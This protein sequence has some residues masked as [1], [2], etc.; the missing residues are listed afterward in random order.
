MRQQRPTLARFAW[1]LT[2]LIATPALAQVDARIVEWV[3]NAP[4]TNNSV[5]ALGYPVPI[6]V[7]TPLPFAG[8]RTYTGLHTRHQDLAAT[9]P[10]VHAENVGATRQGRTIWMYRLG[11]ADF[12]TARGTPEQ[13]MLSNGGIHAREWQ[14][15]EVAT[16]IMELIATSA[17][18]HHLLSYLR[19]NANVM[20]I[21]V[22]NVDGFLQTQRY[23]AHN[24]LGT[25]PNYPEE[26][27]RDGRMR[28][29]NM[30]GNPDDNLLTVDD[31]LLGVDLNRNNAPFW[32][33]NPQRS[34]NNPA[35]LVHHGP[36]QASEPETRA[37]DA[38]A[39]FGPADQ[40]SMYTDMHSF[41]QVHFWGR[42]FNSRLTDLTE[43]LL[44]TFSDHHRQFPAGKNYAYGSAQSV[45]LNQGIGTTDEYF[46]YTYRV[47][48]WT[49]E[50]E[51]S[52][53]APYH[54]PLPGMGADYGGLG[55][56]GHDGF[57]LPDSEVER[58]RTELARTFAV[59]YYQ[60]AG[61]PSVTALRM[62]DSTTGA[63]VF[64]AEW[65]AISDTER[66]L[67]RFQSQPLQLG[68][69]Y[70][71]WIAWDK[72][73][74]WR[75]NGSV[76]PLPGQPGST[77]DLEGDLTAADGTIE[78]ELIA[79]AWLDQPGGAPWGYQR[80]RDD[81]VALGVRL[82]DT[83]ANQDLVQAGVEATLHL[84]TFDMTGNRT[85]ANPATVAR[86][87]NGGWSGY[88]NTE[89]VDGTD[90][91]GS[92]ASIQFAVTAEALEDPF[93][94]E[95]GTSG[96]WFDPD[97]NGEGFVLE[98][99]D[100]SRAVMYWFTYDAEGAQDWYV[101]TGEIR[102]NRILFPDLLRV[103]GGRFGPD[104]DPEQV[105]RTPVGS[106]DFIFSSCDSGA[107]NWVIDRDGG[108][109][110]Q[111]RMDLTRLS[112]VMGIPC[113]EFI[114]APVLEIS[115]RSGSW[116]DPTHSG[117]G[118]ALEILFDQRALVYWFSFDPEGNR[119]WFFGTG[120][121]VGGDVLV[122]DDM[123]TTSGGI[124]GA[125]FD[126]ASVELS[127]WGSLQ[128]QLDCDTGTAEYEP[129]GEDFPAGTLDL[130]RLTSVAGLDCDG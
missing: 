89:G 61:P 10:W 125:E 98:I 43:R 129:A 102:G 118:Y 87:F 4:V 55:R 105:V 63:T 11:D 106:A 53:G 66:R 41:S 16:G 79:G 101:A 51:P 21:P 96:A 29:K 127:P 121:I 68:R 37:L 65:D 107:M 13:A 18:D 8:F 78:T 130:D 108:D 75:E 119:R 99:L 91:G 84:D 122:F 12:L 17:D 90:E 1:L 46:L 27:P 93:V 40:L 123:L 76:V 3:E 114:G 86:W 7:D 94:I 116:Y 111:G 59:A 120:E 85:D 58:V 50:I 128:L 104:F 45:P 52:N 73:M 74:R 15:P 44:R 70:R 5:I 113:N 62:I 35:S 54:A 82:L 20:V 81:A 39:Q 72:P 80:Y 126:P 103:S 30:H 33:S 49:L 48:S 19:E 56:N 26:S 95:P 71:V 42:T 77:L 9:T 2:L 31:H 124:F 22:L 92:D 32:A 23:P 67:H 24:W 6:P 109:R 112:R 28:R 38:A 36:S 83:P 64:E 34:S 14:S 110:R 60:Q 88:E 100:E 117:E 47:P 97:R 115:T 69:D 25:D 57:I